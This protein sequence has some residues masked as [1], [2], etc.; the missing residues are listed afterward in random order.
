MQRY[1]SP[2]QEAPTHV[3]YDGYEEKISRFREQYPNLWETVWLKNSFLQWHRHRE[4]YATTGDQVH[5][6]RML[7]CVTETNPPDRPRKRLRR[8]TKKW[9]R[10]QTYSYNPLALIDLG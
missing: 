2:F 6:D 10:K 4:N 8:K 7:E 1:I 3:E 5:L 9:V